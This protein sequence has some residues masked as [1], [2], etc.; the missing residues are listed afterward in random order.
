M[1]PKVRKQLGEAL[2]G[3]REGGG[4]DLSDSVAPTRYKGGA[5]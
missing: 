5:A 1:L 2:Q 4:G 3:V